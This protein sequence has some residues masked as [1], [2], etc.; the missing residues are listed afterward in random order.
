MSPEQIRATRILLENN[1]V[2]H[3]SKRKAIVGQLE[4]LRN[5]CPHPS[6]KEVGLPPTKMCQDCGKKMK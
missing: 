3:D 5:L 4:S 2:S 6:V 1:L